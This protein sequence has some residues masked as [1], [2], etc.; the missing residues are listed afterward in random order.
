[1]ANSLAT[2]KPFAATRRRTARSRKRMSRPDRSGSIGGRKVVGRE[3]KI[4]RLTAP[5]HPRSV[6]STMRT[7]ELLRRVEG[8]DRTTIDS[9]QHA[10]WVTPERMSAGGDDPRW[11]SE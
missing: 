4:T 2:K 1:M 10:G 11:W 7:D 3:G 8:L 6:P 9:C 5:A